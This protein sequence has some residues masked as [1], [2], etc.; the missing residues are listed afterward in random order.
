[1]S[2]TTDASR[3]KQGKDKATVA[4]FS[5]LCEPVTFEIS[6]N[7]SK[8]KIAQIKD[9]AVVITLIVIQVS[10]VSFHFFSLSSSFY[11]FKKIDQ[12]PEA[13]SIT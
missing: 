7:Q 12:S 10:K 5:I 8:Q 2:A 3:E 11:L 13:L 6:S 4:V 9:E 1:M